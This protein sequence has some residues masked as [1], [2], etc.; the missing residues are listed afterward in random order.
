MGSL[1]VDNAN[2]SSDGQVP[3]FGGNWNND[4]NVL[5]IPSRVCYNNLGGAIMLNLGRV[6]GTMETVPEWDE[7]SC[8]DIVYHRTNVVRIEEEEFSGWEYDEVQYTFPEYVAYLKESL[9]T[10]DN[11]LTQTQLALCDVYELIGG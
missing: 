2:V 3:N 1:G 9:E 10:A 6:R 7:T 5:V 11:T 8:S 4:S